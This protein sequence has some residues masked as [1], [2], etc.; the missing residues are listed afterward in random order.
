MTTEKKIKSARITKE[1]AYKIKNRALAWKFDAE[2]AKLEKQ[3]SVLAD[4]VY[5]V[6]YSP[7]TLEALKSFPE[8]FLIQRT[9]INQYSSFKEALAGEGDQYSYTYAGLPLNFVDAKGE[10]VNRVYLRQA[11]LGEEDIPWFK[12]NHKNLYKRL[13]RFALKINKY[14]RRESAFTAEVKSLLASVNTTKKLLD[15]LPEAEAWIPEVFQCNDLPAADK[16]ASIL[17]I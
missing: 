11:D 13:V 7:A 16:A 9:S 14:Y 12:E 6:L 5:A 15:V 3:G 4:E 1:L 2:F 10:P 8:S 17:N